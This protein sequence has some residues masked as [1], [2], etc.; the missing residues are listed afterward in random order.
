[1]TISKADLITRFTYH[2]PGDVKAQFHKSVRDTVFGC[3]V[4]V[5][6]MT[7]PCREQSIAITKLE[8]ALFWTNAAIARHELVPK[9]TTDAE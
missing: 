8:E 7:P 2:P 5:L 1:M 4:F 9:D 6:K 3:A